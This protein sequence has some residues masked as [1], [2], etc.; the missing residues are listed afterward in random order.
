MSFSESASRRSLGIILRSV[1]LS[2][3]ALIAA[4][5]LAAQDSA[6][7]SIDTRATTPIQ[8][9]FSGIN[10]DLGIPIEYWDANFN[11]LAKQVHYGWVRFPGGSSGDAYNWKTGEE[12]QAWFDQFAVYSAGPPPNIVPLVAGRSGAHLRDAAKRAELLGALLIVCV[13]AFTDSPE[14]TG[15]LAEYVRD[16]H[17][18]VGA[19]ELANEPYLFTQTNS[20]SVAPFFSDAADYLEKMRPFAEAIRKANRDATIAI[21]ADPKATGP[22]A[23]WD[24][25]IASTMA[26]SAMPPYW[27]AITFHYYPALDGSAPFTK[28]MSDETGVLVSESTQLVTVDLQPLST[29]RTRFLV[30]EFD[31]TLPGGLTT[32]QPDGT[33]WGGIYAAEFTMRMSTLPQMM[34]VGAQAISQYSGVDFDVSNEKEINQTVIAAAAS[35]APIDTVTLD[36]EF[37]FYLSAQAAGL[38]VLNGAINEAV[39][40]DQTTVDGGPTVPVTSTDNPPGCATNCTAAPALYA[41]SYSGRGGILSV[42]ITNKG[43]TPVTTT[44]QVNGEREEGPFPVQFV[45]SDVPST[46]NTPTNPTAVSVQSGNSENPVTVPPYS[47]MRLDVTRR[48]FESF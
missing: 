34:Y 17:I 12:E 11:S 29:P 19:W 24:E 9:G 8:R 42:V 32:P 44:I 1:A 48:L 23:L 5:T 28:W 15:E 41:M 47:V 35:N 10:D 30:T 4:Q 25:Q 38:A 3:L 40:V 2:A 6:T 22:R 13:N 21:F 7:I 39:R 37:D 43:A 26:S 31:A 18:R 45:S 20:P 33:L 36:D 16:H 14:S 27:N 46:K